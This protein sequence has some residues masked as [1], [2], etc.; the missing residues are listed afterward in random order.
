MNSLIVVGAGGHGIVVA[1]TAAESGKWNAIAFL[2]DKYPKLRQVG[3]WPVLGKLD[4]AHD[5]VTKYPES[6]I[7]IGNNKLRIQ[8]LQHYQALGFQPSIVVHP[9]AFVSRL[10]T[11]GQGTVVFAQAA[12]NPLAK[13]GA[14][15]IVNTG[16]TVDHHCQLDDGVHIC[17][18]A[19]LA[20]DV[21]IG[22]YSSIGIGASVRDGVRIGHN[23]T[24]GAGAAVIHDQPNEIVAF[25][26]PARSR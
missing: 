23:V 17:P 1:E 9:S 18:G 25:G 20:G 13:L 7:A 10:A 6:I 19:H 4:S 15:C 24:I 26:V 3:E 22:R 5:F 2:D 8:L 14:G 16:A 11:L 12:V 21:S